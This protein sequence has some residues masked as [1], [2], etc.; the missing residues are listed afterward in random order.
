MALDIWALDIWA[1]ER[2]FWKDIG[3]DIY[4]LCIKY[5]IDISNYPMSISKWFSDDTFL[6]IVDINVYLWDKWDKFKTLLHK[7]LDTYWCAGKHIYRPG[8]HMLKQ[9]LLMFLITWI[10]VNIEMYKI[11]TKMFPFY[12]QF[13]ILTWNV[14]GFQATVTFMESF[15]EMH[16]KSSKDW[17]NWKRKKKQ[18]WNLVTKDVFSNAN[19]Q[20]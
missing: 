4:I 3:M 7:L 14:T 8:I 20:R 18:L 13:S 16:H 9:T 12:C 2:Y 5:G 19:S 11:D 17:I 10:Q 6:V 15:S 1:L